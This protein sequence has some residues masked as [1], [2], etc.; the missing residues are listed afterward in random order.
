MEPSLTPTKLKKNFRTHKNVDIN[1]M[2]SCIKNNLLTIL[3]DNV[4]KSLTSSKYF[5][6]WINTEA[7]RLIRI[8]H[9]GYQ[10]AKRRNDVQSWKKYKD[11][12]KLVQ[13]KCRESHDNNLR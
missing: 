10:K 12:K 7:K 11:I 2:W 5:H 1:E 4:P 3:E 13:K 6:P 8:K 9:K